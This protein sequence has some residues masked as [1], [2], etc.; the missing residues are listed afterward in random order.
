MFCI[1]CIIYNIG[2]NEIILKVQKESTKK[3]KEEL[4]GE[5]FL[6]NVTIIL[7]FAIFCLTAPDDNLDHFYGTSNE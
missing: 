2:N 1:E 5:K 7:K 6:W 4:S 3:L